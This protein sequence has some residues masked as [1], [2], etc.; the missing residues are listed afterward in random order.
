MALDIRGKTNRDVTTTKSI[1]KAIRSTPFCPVQANMNERLG[2]IISAPECTTM[3]SLFLS[4]FLSTQ[5]WQNR[6]EHRGN[7]GTDVTITKSRIKAIR[8]T[9]FCPIQASIIEHSRTRIT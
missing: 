8:S 1:I 3:I 7:K 6:I 9:P 4:V 5:T 2:T